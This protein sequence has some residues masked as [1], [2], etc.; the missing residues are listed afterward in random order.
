MECMGMLLSKQLL[1]NN[2]I[3]YYIIKYISII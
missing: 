3:I 1:Y 2:T